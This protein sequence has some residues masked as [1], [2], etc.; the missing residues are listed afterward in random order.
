MRIWLKDTADKYWFIYACDES[1]MI[2][3]IMIMNIYSFKYVLSS[4][5]ND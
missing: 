3:T 2:S 5:Q 1:E 4:F